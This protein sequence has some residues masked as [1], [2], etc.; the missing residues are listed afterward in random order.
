KDGG[1]IAEADLFFLVDLG[2]VVV[3]EDS[4]GVGLIF[5]VYLAGAVGLEE[6]L[7]RGIAGGGVRAALLDDAVF[8]LDFLEEMGYLGRKIGD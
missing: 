5:G 8:G 2:F 3:G 1:A 6:L 7:D 4:F